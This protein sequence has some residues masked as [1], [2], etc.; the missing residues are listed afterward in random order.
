[1][2]TTIRS[3]GIEIR[4]GVHTGECE[5]MPGDV[6]GIA[7]HIAARVM[8]VAAPGQVLVSSTV[9]DLVVGSGLRFEGAG[10]HTL[11]GVPGEWAVY[12]LA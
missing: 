6:G 8:A 1:V 9:R 7:V 3:L 2:A 12:A 11:R 5:M 4:A 10:T